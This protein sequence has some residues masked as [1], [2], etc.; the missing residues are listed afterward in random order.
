MLGAVVPVTLSHPS[1]TSAG[2]LISTKFGKAIS[3]FVK[4]YTDEEHSSWAKADSF[5]LAGGSYGGFIA[6]EYA[7]A[8]PDR[9]KGLILRDTMAYGYWGCMNA[10]T[11]VLSS[12]RI[13]PDPERQLRLWTGRVRDDEDFK[14]GFM[15][16]MGMYG[17]K[18][19]Q[20]EKAMGEE[21][22]KQTEVDGEAAKENPKEGNEKQPGQQLQYHYRTHNA[23]YSQIMPKWDLRDRL[24]EI[25][26]KTLVTVGRQDR[27]VPVASSEEICKGIGDSARLKIFENSG[28]SPPTEE[29][30]AYQAAV[31]EFVKSLNL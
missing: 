31:R 24:K 20:P 10:L 18:P 25:K 7:L 21:P 22:T 11:Q 5:V 30:E 4:Q 1:R 9:L 3:R 27:I 12:D 26:V 13:S 29:P 14:E 6:L 16:I 8:H 23:A 28:H 2:W 17:A 15:E 19:N